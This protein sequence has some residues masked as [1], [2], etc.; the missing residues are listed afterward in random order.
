[1]AKF[2]G[3]IGYAQ[4]VEVEPGYW[5]NTIIERNY[6]GDIE[7]N[8]SRNENSGNVNDN[9]TL[10][11]TISVVAD[12][13]ANENFQHMKYVTY[14]GTKWKIVSVE[15][16]YPRLILTIGGMYNEEMARSSEEA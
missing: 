16:K 2:S 15:V 12:P 5:E 8:Y 9:I 11:N 10:N 7:R 1:M 4:C 6:Y 14:L 3:K 13:Y